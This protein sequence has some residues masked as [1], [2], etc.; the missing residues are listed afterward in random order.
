VAVRSD[1]PLD[2]VPTAPST[3]GRDPVETATGTGSV[4][5]QVRTAAAEVTRRARSVR[6][7]AERVEPYAAELVASGALEATPPGDH[8]ATGSDDPWTAADGDPETVAGRV[9]ALDTIN[10][11]SGWHPV[12]RKRLGRSGAVNM[13]NGL[14]AW[15]A[16]DEGVSAARLALL[17]TDTA[18]QVFDQPHDDGPVDELM[19]LFTVALNDLGRLVLDDH[20]GSFTALV[21]AAG[22]SA[23]AMVELLG[24]MPFFGDVS[25]YDDLE[26]PLYK[27]AQLVSADLHR[28]LGGQ[29]LG[30]FDDLDRLTAFADNLVPHVLRLDGVLTYDE[31]LIARIEAGELLVAGSPEEVEI[32]AVGVHAVEQVRAALAERG[33]LVPSWHLDQVLWRR[34]GG[35]AYKAVPRHRARSVFY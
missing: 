28:A 24:A 19:A 11:G 1:A 32:R 34:G 13:A 3:V 33:R 27:R 2:P 21:A 9:F 30:H 20:G 12:V 22:G 31:D 6:L 10:F 29:G 35:A 8:E 14:S 16:A 5:E 18:H 17:D 26:V 7:V 25:G 4:L 15:L 23:A